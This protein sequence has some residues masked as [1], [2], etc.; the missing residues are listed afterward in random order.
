MCLVYSHAPRG[1]VSREPSVF[2]GVY[3]SSS[4][5]WTSYFPFKTVYTV[6]FVKME[7]RVNCFKVFNTFYFHNQ[8]SELPP[9]RESCFYTRLSAC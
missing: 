5:R 2:E 1:R 4:Q 3:F 8:F 7:S 6:L 9:S